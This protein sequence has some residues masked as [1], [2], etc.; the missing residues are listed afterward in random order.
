MRSR[1]AAVSPSDGRRPGS[2]PPAG[3][4]QGRPMAMIE[5][6]GDRRA[7][8]PSIDRSINTDPL[9]DGIIRVQSFPL[10][11]MLSIGGLYTLSYSLCS[12][13]CLVLTITSS[14]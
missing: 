3:A 12:Q 5:P 11:L 6:A 9:H 8:A 2:L 13:S 7:S 14:K 10:S 4:A 1:C